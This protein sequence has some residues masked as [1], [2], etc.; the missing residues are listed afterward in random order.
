MS[1]KMPDGI[2]WDDALR[3]SSWTLTQAIRFTTKYKTTQIAD[4]EH[5]FLRDGLLDDYDP[6]LLRHPYYDTVNHAVFT[7]ELE[8]C[9]EFTRTKV[10]PLDFVR[11]RARKKK[12]GQMPPP[13][14]IYHRKNTHEKEHEEDEDD[15]RPLDSWGDEAWFQTGNEYPRLTPE[16]LR[17]LEMHGMPGGDNCWDIACA[18]PLWSLSQ[19]IRWTTVIKVSKEFQEFYDR[20]NA[21]PMKE[22]VDFPLLEHPLTGFAV[23][24]IYAGDLNNYSKDETK[25]S[26]DTEAVDNVKVKPDE[27]LKWRE[28]FSQLWPLRP[29][30]VE[31]QTRCNANNGTTT[32]APTEQAAH[33]TTTLVPE[34]DPLHGNALRYAAEREKLLGAA[35]WCIY[36][37]PDKCVE[38]QKPVAARIAGQIVLH[39]DEMWPGKKF[40]R[41]EVHTANLLSRWF[42]HGRVDEEGEKI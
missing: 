11:W 32:A 41:N 35:L 2:T 40:N 15:G 31:A 18:F 20:A 25:I 21:D 3:Y 26:L 12:W 8:S 38:N 13:L 29:E 9:C 23:N 27:F 19:A 1:G 30:M 42:T 10:K 17:R 39:Y 7:G 24:A 16:D 14:V 37:H 36:N 22:A 5:D 6:E 4:P 33:V 34:P 28:K